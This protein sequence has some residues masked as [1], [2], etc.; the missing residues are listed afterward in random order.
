MWLE[1]RPKEI[2]DLDRI[3][4]E[5]RSA[6]M[7][8]IKGR[9]TRPE[10][11]VRRILRRLGIGYRLHA[12]G[13]PGRPDIVMRGRRR[14]IFV[15]GCFWHRHEDCR[16]SYL[17]KSRR[18]FW[19]EKFAGTVARDLRNLTLLRKNGWKVLVIWE[20]EIADA[21]LAEQRIM[22]F[23]DWG[24]DAKTGRTGTPSVTPRPKKV[25]KASLRRSRARS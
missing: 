11:L 18:E 6:N 15:H 23:L 4:V 16:Y 14:V 22:A 9:D 19:A 20:C 1:C 5:Q 25:A 10:L 7:A 13:L 2:N 24:T 21:K 12:N 8:A 3:T 17:P